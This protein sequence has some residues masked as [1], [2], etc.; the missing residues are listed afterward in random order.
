MARKA[1]AEKLHLV[2]QNSVVGEI[3]KFVLIRYKRHCQQ[4]HVGLLRRAVSFSIVAATA[5]GHHIG[6]DIPTASGDRNHVISG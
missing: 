6:P 4:L 3:Q 2:S 1:S 5:G